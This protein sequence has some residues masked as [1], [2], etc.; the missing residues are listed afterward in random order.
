MRALRQRQR[1]GLVTES[2]HGQREISNENII[3]RLFFEERFQFAARLPPTFLG[4]RIVA[5]EFCTPSLTKS[6]VGHYKNPT[7]DLAWQVFPLAEG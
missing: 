4:G 2:H 5:G 6:A 3:F 1:A 7:L